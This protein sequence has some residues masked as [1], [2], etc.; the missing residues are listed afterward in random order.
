[1]NVK[2]GPGVTV[3][4]IELLADGESV[5]V[6]VK[7]GF[8]VGVLVGGTGVSVDRIT[9]VDVKLGI[10]DAVKVGSGEGVGVADAVYM[11]NNPSPAQAANKNTPSNPL[12]TQKIV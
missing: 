5:T 2:E 9:G 8:F 3:T 1:M 7:V 4:E 6:F 10:N 12:S 11:V